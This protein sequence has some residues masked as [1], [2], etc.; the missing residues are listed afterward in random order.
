MFTM[1]RPLSPHSAFPWVPSTTSLVKAPAWGITLW[2]L[3]FQDFRVASFHCHIRK[4]RVILKT[5][6]KTEL[7]EN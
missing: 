3:S 2:I 1:I 6:W 4:V 7:Y 5:G